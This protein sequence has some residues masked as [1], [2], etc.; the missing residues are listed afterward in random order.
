VADAMIDVATSAKARHQAGEWYT[1]HVMRG[2][3]RKNSCIFKGLHIA[4]DQLACRIA[5]HPP[6]TQP[7]TTEGDRA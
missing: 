2:I 6:I 3:T 5:H 4:I 7:F 1:G